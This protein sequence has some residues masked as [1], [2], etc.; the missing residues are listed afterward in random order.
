MHKEQQLVVEAGL[1]NS[2]WGME[3][4]WKMVQYANALLST[5]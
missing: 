1:L 5:S 3:D 2:V 4:E